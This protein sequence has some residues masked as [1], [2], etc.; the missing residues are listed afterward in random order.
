[1]NICCKFE[2]LRTSIT[3]VIIGEANLPPPPILRDPK[4]PPKIGLNEFCFHHKQSKGISNDIQ[5]S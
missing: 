5:S 2:D 4:T 3:E 1:M